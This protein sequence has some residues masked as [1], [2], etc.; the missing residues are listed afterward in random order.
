MLTTPIQ[1]RMPDTPII[2]KTILLKW[3]T[4][5]PDV[6]SRSEGSSV[7]IDSHTANVFI[8][9]FYGLMNNIGINQEFWYPYL[10]ANGYYN[11]TQY[12]GLRTNIRTLDLPTLTAY[13]DAFTR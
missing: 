3:S 6:L 2:D 11:P 5:M 9:D 4:A 8:F 12:D 10:L 13:Y 7:T 1:H